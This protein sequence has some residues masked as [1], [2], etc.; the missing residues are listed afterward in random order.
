MAGYVVEVYMSR[1]G[2][3]ALD[4]LTRPSAPCSRRAVAGRNPRRP[5]ALGLPPRGRDL[6][7]LLRRA[8]ARRDPGDLFSS[9]PDARTDHEGDER[10]TLTQ[11]DPVGKPAAQ[12]PVL[13]HFTC[14][15][16]R[17]HKLA[18]C[19]AFRSRRSDSNR[20]RL[21]EIATRPK[22]EIS[23][24]SSTSLVFST[25]KTQ[26]AVLQGVPEADARTRTGDP[27]ITSELSP[28]DIG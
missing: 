23:P 12:Q 19:R 25:A 6:L 4:D 16:N 13:E 3:S 15:L 14:L 8:V 10:R 17:E 22:R 1:L 11:N 27:F 20:G 24:C 9:R 26:V 2:A 18:I 28:S 5:R 7:P 21:H